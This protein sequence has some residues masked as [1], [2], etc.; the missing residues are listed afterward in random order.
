VPANGSPTRSD[1]DLRARVQRALDLCRP[2]LEGGAYT[3]ILTDRA[4]DAAAPRGRAA[5]PLESVILAVKDMIAVQGLPRGGGSRSQEHSAACE[6][7]APAVAA[8]LGAGAVLIGLT[9]LHE[10]AF[11]VTGI[12]GYTGTPHNPAAPG[13][14]PG[15]SSSGSAVAVATGSADIALG[16][17]TGGSVRIPAA[18]CG[19][20]GYK[21]PFDAFPTH[22]VLPLAVSLDHVGVLARSAGLARTVDEVISGR[23]EASGHASTAPN[24]AVD[25]SRL[26]RC[27]ATVA[28]AF[29]RAIDALSAKYRIVEV[30]LP[31]SGEVVEVTGT[32]MFYEA[33]QVY[34]ALALD[35]HSGLG[36]DVRAR[37]LSGMQITSAE[38]AAALERRHRLTEEVAVIVRQFDAIVEPTVP[39]CAPPIAEAPAVGS[40]LVAHTRLAN[41]TGLPAIS[42]PIP[43]PGLPV[44]LQLTACDRPALFGAA[45]A[46]ETLLSGPAPAGSTTWP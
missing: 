39:M 46:A 34:G 29:A 44:G 36:D 1:V 35:E 8:L 27:E 31:P 4:L 37:L 24:L 2:S 25:P 32:I 13:R 28:T 45:E 38:Y 20:V 19:V 14:V 9:A 5:G 40:E 11:G 15:G 17:D 3:R 43:G 26:E 23:S 16:T 30:E 12:N 22:G 6:E 33:A 42:L 7:D 41:L 21:P 10:L 18:L